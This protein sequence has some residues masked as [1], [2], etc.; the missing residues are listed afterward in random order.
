MIPTDHFADAVMT[1]LAWLLLFLAV[2]SV[3]KFFKGGDDE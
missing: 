1:G 3:V 2:V